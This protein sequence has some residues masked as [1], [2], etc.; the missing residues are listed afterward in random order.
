L[1]RLLRSQDKDSGEY[2]K[3]NIEHV[4]AL[5]TLICHLAAQH[6]E[7]LRRAVSLLEQASAQN[8]S[9]LKTALLGNYCDRFIELHHQRIAATHPEPEILS[10]LAWKLLIS[11][12]FYSGNNGR[13]L[14][15]AAIF[16]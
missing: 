11:L 8:Q 4:K 13:C 10:A 7:L 1:L 6:Q 12:L 3:F 16:E 14:L 9:P 15:W 5:V 2:P